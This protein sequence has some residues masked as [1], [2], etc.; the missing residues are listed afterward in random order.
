MTIYS[1]FLG[2]LCI[3]LFKFNLFM[4]LTRPFGM[5]HPLYACVFV[6]LRFYGVLRPKAEVKAIKFSD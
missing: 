6:S 5:R 4:Y 1:T 3:P 2:N